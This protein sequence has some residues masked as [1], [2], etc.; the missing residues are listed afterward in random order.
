MT[1]DLKQGSKLGDNELMLRIGRGGM[2]HASEPKIP[3]TI[4]WSL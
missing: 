1:E 3:R 2:A 4:G